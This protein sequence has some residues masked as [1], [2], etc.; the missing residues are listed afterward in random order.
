MIAVDSGGSDI[1][2]D[3]R[4]RL[5]RRAVGTMAQ[6]RAFQ[7]SAAFFRRTLDDTRVFREGECQVV[8]N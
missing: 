3:R 8:D 6:P 5:P 7:Q 1:G 4:R 2:P